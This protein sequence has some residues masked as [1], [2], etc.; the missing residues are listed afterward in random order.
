[1]SRISLRRP[2]LALAGIL[3]AIGGCSENPSGPNG[4]QF[5]HRSRGASFSVSGGSDATALITPLGGVVA[6]A[7]G[8]RIVFPIGAVSKP[9]QITLHSSTE[10]VGVEVE[11]HGLRFPN[12]RRPVLTLN[13]A[14]SDVAAYGA[15]DVVYVNESGQ[16]ADVLHTTGN[17]ASL[18][19]EL[20]HFS[21]Y[22]AAGH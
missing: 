16:V 22:T 10:Y 8:D 12:G 7:A 4:Y 19:A 2:S 5:I 18:Q 6:T 17:G 20:P 3:I 11:P 13:T 15:V 1:M 14:G 21:I 9:T